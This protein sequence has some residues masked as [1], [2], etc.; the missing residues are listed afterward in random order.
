M[1]DAGGAEGG[2]S[3]SEPTSVLAWPGQG[4]G[5]AG[6]DAQPAHPGPGDVLEGEGVWL[7]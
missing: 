1:T 3:G 4:L 2:S 6:A 5:W 7:V